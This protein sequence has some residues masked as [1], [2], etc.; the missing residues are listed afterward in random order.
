MQQVCR[1]NVGHM[2]TLYFD[3]SEVFCKTLWV[4]V[5]FFYAHYAAIY[6]PHVAAC[7]ARRSHFGPVQVCTRFAWFANFAPRWK[8]NG[9]ARVSMI[10]I[11][12]QKLRKNYAENFAKSR[13]NCRKIMQIKLLVRKYAKITRAFVIC[14]ICIITRSVAHPTW[15]MWRQRRLQ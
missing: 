6:A 2:Q 10:G 9:C 3:D 13:Q 14:A 11:I 12:K 5:S 8:P 1:A 15:L 7:K 4:H